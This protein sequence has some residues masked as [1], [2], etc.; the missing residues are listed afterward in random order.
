MSNTLRNPHAAAFEAWT[1][2]KAWMQANLGLAETMRDSRMGILSHQ[3]QKQE[4]AALKAEADR[5]L[6]AAMKQLRG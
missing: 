3:A 5:L 6:A 4:V 2:Y 1:A